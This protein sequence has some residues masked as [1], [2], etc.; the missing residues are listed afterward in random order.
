MRKTSRHSLIVWLTASMC[1]L[2]VIRLFCL[3]VVSH[4][5][6]EQRAADASERYVYEAAPRGD[7]TDRSGRLLAGSRPVYS[8]TLDRTGADEKTLLESGRKAI[9]LLDGYGEDDHLPYRELEKSMT[10]QDTALYI[11]VEIC[12]GI[13]EKA[14]SGMEK[15]K[16]SGIN[17]RTDH[18]RYYPQG[19]LA[20]HIIGYVGSISE[21]ETDEYNREKGYRNDDIIGKSG[22]ERY[23]ESSLKGVDGRTGYQVDASGKVRGTLESR[24]AEKG[25]SVRL[26]IDSDLQKIT[27]DALKQAVSKAS[28]GGTLRKPLRRCADGVCSECRCGGGSCDRCGQRGDPGDGQH[29]G[30]RS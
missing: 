5:K 23:C 12:S 7:I 3:T 16:L 2:L 19:S 26:T 30:L 22:I 4:D 11:P 17:V 25:S 18:V 14:A 20:S 24:K 15:A 9:E 8:V 29:S 28:T 21:E 10:S 27:E 6:W 1:L 13:S